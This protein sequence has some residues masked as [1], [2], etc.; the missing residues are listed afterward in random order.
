MTR[1]G[2]YEMPVIGI[3]DAVT[4]L[5]KIRDV[6]GGRSATREVAAEAMGMSATGGQTGLVFSSMAS[7]G[8]IDTGGKEIRVTDLGETVLFGTGAET[9]N[10]KVESVRRI[11]L[12]RELFAK[13]GPNPSEDQVRAFLRQDAQLEVSRVPDVLE[14]VMRLA[15]AMSQYAG[16]VTQ[17]SQA[18]L[19][20]ASSGPAERRPR[21][22]GAS[23]DEDSMEVRIGSYHFSLPLDDLDLAGN[24]AKSNIDGIIASLKAR[25]SNRAEEETTGAETG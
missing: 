16:A 25:K 15:R 20:R 17:P 5:R 6:A 21:E 23:A 24:L 2:K 19:E 11:D 12:F 13:Y 8:I 1:V 10:C 4:R 9:T 14:R 22:V 18:Q 7:Y 3:D